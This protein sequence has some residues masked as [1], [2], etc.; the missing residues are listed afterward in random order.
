MKHNSEGKTTEK[1][2]C[3]GC[4]SS[5]RTIE[6]QLWGPEY[7]FSTIKDRWYAKEDIYQAPFIYLFL[8]S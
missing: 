3:K 6:Y 7:N 1:N 8:R 4:G 2:I 5:D